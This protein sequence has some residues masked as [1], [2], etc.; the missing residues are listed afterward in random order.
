MLFR[1]R[2]TSDTGGTEIVPAGPLGDAEVGPRSTVVVPVSCR[3]RTGAE[4]EAASGGDA[5][6]ED[7]GSGSQGEGFAGGGGERHRLGV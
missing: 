1:S 3:E 6:G 4:V 5:G 7:P 2:P